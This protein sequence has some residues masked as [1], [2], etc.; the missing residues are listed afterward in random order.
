MLDSRQLVSALRSLK[1]GDFT[2]RLPEDG[3]G[4]DSEIAA[5]FN[6][7]VSLNQEMT[8]EFER[9]SQVVGKEG[10]IGQRGRVKSATGGRGPA[11]RPDNELREDMCQPPPQGGRRPRGGGQAG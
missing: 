4:V 2:V 9:L 1:R 3:D 8:R 6:E 10:K 11:S 5:L 7:V